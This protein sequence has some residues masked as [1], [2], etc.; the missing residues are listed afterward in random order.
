MGGD[1]SVNGPTKLN[2]TISKWVW[3]ESNAALEEGEAVCYNWNYTG[4]GAT[5]SD[6]RRAN[7]VETPT[8][9]N[10]QWFAGVAARA[11]SAKSGG[12]LIEIY[13]PGSVCNIRLGINTS[14]VAGTI[15]WNGILTFDVTSDYE[16]QFRYAGLIGEGSAIPLQT[17]TA[18]GVNTATCLAKLQTGE[19]SGGVE[20]VPLVATGAIGTL[21]IGG[22][23]LVTGAAI[24]TGNNTYTLADAALTGLRKKFQVIT[25]EITAYD[26]I[27]TVTTGTESWGS[28]D[29]DTITW[30]GDNTTLNKAVTLVWDGAWVATHMT[31]TEP[32]PS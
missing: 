11:Y 21:M 17:V 29:L 10:A 32:T 13:V 16:G 15:G 31:K 2:P 7:N 5:Y 19:P 12:Q 26:F 9:L 20:V 6:A 14:T 27:I 8:T 4:D 22:T 3:Y 25:A 28:G 30:E 1:I 24:D 23:T 18:D